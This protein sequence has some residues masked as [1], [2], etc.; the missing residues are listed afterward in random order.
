MWL[1]G[2]SRTWGRAGERSERWIEDGVGSVIGRD[3]WVRF[4]LLDCEFS[5]YI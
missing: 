5:I 2:E 3:V 4:V 1:V